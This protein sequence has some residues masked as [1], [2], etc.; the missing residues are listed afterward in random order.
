MT[1]QQDEKIKVA[2]I[3]LGSMARAGELPALALRDDVDIV[4]VCDIE[5]HKMDEIS[6]QYKVKE[7]Y[8]ELDELIEK[9]KPDVAFV[10]T[11]K[12][13]HAEIVTRLLEA[14]IHVFCEKPMATSLED[15]RSMTELAMKR[16]RLLMIGFNRRYAPVYQKA[17]YYLENTKPDVC[18]AQKNRPGTE[19]RA[20]LENMIHVVDIVRYF[21]GECVELNAH[22]QYIDKLNE[23]TTATMLKFESGGIAFILGN[24]TC[25]QWMERVELYGNGK[26]I[27]VNC[28]DDVTIIDSEQEHRQN[29]SPLNNGWASVIEKMGFKGEVDHF[30]DCVKTDMVP[31]TTASD[32]L[33]THELM[34]KILIAANLPSMSWEG[35]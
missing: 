24:R 30:I 25:G 9:S 34:D 26:S 13:T 11:P 21:M 16:D 3:G 20:T 6:S 19:Y 8:Q 12:D 14:D 10:I 22:S 32:A 33:K 23:N 28:P 7:K 1:Y 15:A 4:G 31:L 29:M 27:I 2:V 5:S 35:K 17:K 18:V